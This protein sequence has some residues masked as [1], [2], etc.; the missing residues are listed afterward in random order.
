[1]MKRRILAAVCCVTLLIAGTGCGRFGE[2]KASHRN[3]RLMVNYF[4]YS[5]HDYSLQSGSGCYLQCNGTTIHCTEE[6]ARIYPKLAEALDK[7]AA[8]TVDLAKAFSDEMDE[9]AHEFM[10]DGASGF[11][12]ETVQSAVKRADEKAVSIAS[13]WYS[14][15]GGAH[16]A[17]VYTARNIDPV[18]GEEIR[19]SDVVKDKQMLDELLLAR[20]RELY[21]DMSF[22]EW[23][24]PFGNYD[25]N[26]TKNNDESNAYTFTLDPDG[27]SF[28]FSAYELGSYAEGRQVV[29]LLYRDSPTLFVKDYAVSGGYASGLI[30]YERYDLGG[31]GTADEI[32]YYCIN[33]EFNPASAYE[34]IYVEK[35]GQELDFNLHCYSVETF[36]MHTEDNRDYLYVIAHMD[37]DESCLHIYDLSGEKFTLA[38]EEAYGLPHADWEE[39][40]LYGYELITDSDDFVLTF[41]CDL[42]ATFNA[43][44]NTSVGPDG[45]PLLPED[46][47]YDVPDNVSTLHSAVPLKADIVNEKGKVVKKNVTIPAGKTFK[48]LRTDGE[49]T[50]DAR[51]ADGRIARLELTRSDDNP[52]AIVNGQISEE[53]AFKELFYGG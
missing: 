1:M 2:N 32:G 25:I 48:L 50:V 28:Y 44:F 7:D 16:G 11:Y 45:R 31:D 9:E 38:E 51:L 8:E 19:L 42:L 53:E 35:N 39:E 27:L 14:Y 36:L 49:K 5:K 22:L 13:E 30:G 10:R 40:D 12:V 23:D 17:G 37:N 21:P 43:Y 33:D 52:T 6:T 46:G 41:R 29:K 26:I 47:Y 24:E 4:D 34:K 15:M 20:F 18:T 3:L